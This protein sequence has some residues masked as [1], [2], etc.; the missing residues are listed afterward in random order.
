MSGGGGE[1]GA[2]KDLRRH[3]SGEVVVCAGCKAGLSASEDVLQAL[4]GTWHERCFKCAA[5][6]EVLPPTETFAEDGG[7]P[8]HLP[9]LARKRAA[10]CRACGQPIEGEYVKAG[11]AT[12]HEACFV[13]ASCGGSL[14]GGYMP[15]K[16]DG[17]PCCSAACHAK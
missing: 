16:R 17:L 11:D 10:V 1:S 3:G 2:A 12:Y 4:G 13:C 7:A 6:G 14:E 8:Y 15:R 5:C 9:C